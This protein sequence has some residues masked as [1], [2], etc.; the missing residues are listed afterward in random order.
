MDTDA[1]YYGTNNHQTE[2]GL[3]DRSPNNKSPSNR[4]NRLPPT[5]SNDD[6]HG[7][8]FEPQD[9]LRNKELVRRQQSQRQQAADNKSLERDGL[10]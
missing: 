4:H 10:R 8:A 9:G 1:S 3:I 7:R 2:T 6:V 5:F